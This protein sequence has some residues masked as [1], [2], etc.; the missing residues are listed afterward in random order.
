MDRRRR[1]AG[2]CCQNCFA[3]WLG[4][5]LH[6]VGFLCFLIEV[7]D[8]DILS[9]LQQPHEDVLEFLGGSFTT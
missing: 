2:L 7:V 9:K 8:I 1:L 5:S 6:Q 4:C 3:R